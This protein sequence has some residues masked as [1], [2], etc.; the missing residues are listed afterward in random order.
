MYRIKMK[1]LFLMVLGALLLLPI[2]VSSPVHGYHVGETD[3]YE[4]EAGWVNEPAHPAERN[5]IRIFVSE[6]T[7]DQT[8]YNVQGISGLEETL[9]VDIAYSDEQISLSLTEDHKRLG[10]YYAW[11]E[12]VSTGTYNLILSG[13]I[14]D[15]DV[16][17]TLALPPVDDIQYERFPSFGLSKKIATQ[18]SSDADLDEISKDTKTLQQEVEKLKQTFDTAKE[19]AELYPPVLYTGI[20]LAILGIVIGSIALF[21]RR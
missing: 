16:S 17:M 6:L 3:L 15:V 1:K 2:A 20:T 11:V 13:Q 21:K 7:Y 18:S 19:T 12:P 14:K 10:Q 4:I 9:K 5:G 8:P